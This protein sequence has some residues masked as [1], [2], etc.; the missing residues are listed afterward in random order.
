MLATLIIEDN[1]TSR[2]YLRQLLSTRYPQVRVRDAASGTL[3][4]REIKDMDPDVILMNIRL[5]DLNGIQVLREIRR[6]SGRVIIVVLADDDTPEYRDAA[7]R[8][9]ADYFV[10]I[11]SSSTEEIDS[12]FET[13]FRWARA[14]VDESYGGAG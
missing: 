10:A 6:R 3:A 5:P 1:V 9:G 13:I 12:L 4:L 2:E 11:W 7:L 14:M 8:S